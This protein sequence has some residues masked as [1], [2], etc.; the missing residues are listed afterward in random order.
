MSRLLIYMPAL[1]EAETIREVIQGIPTSYSGISEVST[2]VINDGSTDETI[3]ESKKANAQV[4]THNY[5]KGVGAAFHSAVQYALEH[6]FDI[7]VS[8]D[9][10]GQFDSS[11]IEDLIHPILEKKA[12]FCL[13][14]RF[15]NKRPENMPKVKYWGNKQV[16]RIVG[17]IGKVPIQDASCGFRSYSREALMS[18]NLQGSFT[19]THETILDL[20]DKGFKVSQIPVRVTYFEGRISRVAN[21]VFTYG[22]RTSKIIVKCLKDYA[23]F[24]FFMNIALFFLLLAAALGGFVL[25]HWF[26]NGAITPYKSLGIFA[27]TLLGFAFFVAI[28]ALIADILGRMRQ[29]QEKI[30]Y[31]LK[32]THYD[33]DE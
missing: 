10:D 24:Y 28:L 32:K 14:V 33:K 7:L 6:K 3:A 29:N 22:I 2:L 5:N 12:D 8:M 11:Q 4:V 13:G 25:V 31:F 9:A 1:N 20:L 27:L 15:E 23:P 16:N 18:L 26:V 19:Y 21:N 30:L 17:F